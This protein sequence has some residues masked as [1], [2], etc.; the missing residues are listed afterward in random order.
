VLK[1]PSQILHVHFNRGLHVDRA[2]YRGIDCITPV[3]FYTLSFQEMNKRAVTSELVIDS[4]MFMGN[5]SHL[6]REHF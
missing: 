6:F 2:I 5:A 1:K 3:K 4:T